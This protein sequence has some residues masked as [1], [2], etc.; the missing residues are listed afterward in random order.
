M[1]GAGV[2]EGDEEEDDEAVETEG[3]VGADETGGAGEGGDSLEAFFF[4]FRF[5]GLPWPFNEA[6][7]AA[8]RAT[9]ITAQRR[10]GDYSTQLGSTSSTSARIQ[11]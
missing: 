7:S 10:R 8:W 5:I 3:V 11:W 1:G 2:Q 4:F 9:N 6:A